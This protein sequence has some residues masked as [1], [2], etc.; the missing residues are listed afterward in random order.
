[1][2]N[3]EEPKTKSRSIFKIIVSTALIVIAL[4][5]CTIV[6]FLFYVYSKI[7]TIAEIKN[8]LLNNTEETQT[9]EGTDG[10]VIKDKHPY[11]NAEQEELAES[12]GV[13]PATLPTEITPELENCVT[14]TVGQ[15]RINEIING[16][17]PTTSEILKS[18]DCL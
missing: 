1:M 8:P 13:D 3:Q 17:E 11:L 4:S 2:E 14:E 6:V 10:E 16:S 5:L 15:D 18:L 12:F 9:V 7:S